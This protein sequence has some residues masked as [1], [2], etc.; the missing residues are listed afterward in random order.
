MVKSVILSREEGKTSV[1]VAALVAGGGIGVAALLAATVTGAV[2][3]NRIPVALH[4]KGVV[5]D[6]EFLVYVVE[7]DAPF[8]KESGLDRNGEL[9]TRDEHWRCKQLMRTLRHQKRTCLADN[10][11]RR[12]RPMAVVC[13]D[14]RSPLLGSILGN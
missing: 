10:G 4:I 5:L 11:S 6:N 7:E 3:A 14:Q 12:P 2:E 8:F 1:G 9:C 13:R